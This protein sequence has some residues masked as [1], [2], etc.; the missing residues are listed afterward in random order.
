MNT[1]VLYALVFLREMFLTMFHKNF[2]IH[3]VI[4]FTVLIFSSERLIAQINYQDFAS[5]LGLTSDTGTTI[6]GGSGVSF[7]DYNNDGFD[8]ITLT[9]GENTPVRFYTNLNGSFFI[10]ED[11][12]PVPVSGN[13]NY[14]TRCSNWI[15]YDNDGDK[16]LFLTSDTDGNRLFQNQNGSLVDVTIS[17]GFPTDNLV[18][19]G[20]SWGDINNDGCLDV[21]ISNRVGGTSIT[22]YF[23]VNNCDGTFTDATVS[24]GLSN[25]SELTFCSA[26]FD[27][28]NDGY[29]DLYVANDKIMPNYLYKNNGDGTFTDVSQSSGTNLVIDAMSVTIGDYNSDGFFDIFM[30]NT[31]ENIST[32]YAEGTVL[33]KNNGDETFTDVTSTAQTSLD[34]FSWGSNFIDSENDGDLDIYVNTQYTNSDGQPTFGFFENNNDGTFSMPVLPGFTT[35]DY[36]S[37]SS[38]IGDYN[39]DGK[40]DILSHNDDNEN[41][42]LWVNTSDTSA[43][44]YI[45][46]HLE[47]IISNKDGIGS[48]IEIST[49]GKKQFGYVL[50]GEGYMSQNSFTQHFG[51]GNS[52]VIDYIK[53]TWLSGTVDQFVDVPANQTYNIVEGTGTAL[54]VNNNEINDIK[55]YP[56]PVK[57]RLMI[58]AKDL[59]KLVHL[60]NPLGQE[61]MRLEPNSLDADIDT[62]TLSTGTYLVRINTVDK[63][64]TVR[65][66]KK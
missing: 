8:D 50:G 53:V 59:I 60:C 45:K 38:A 21:Y 47:G 11:L 19:Y 55:V 20:A 41:A 17:A 34:S 26:F 9:T 66:I 58:K 5:S 6:F 29:Q 13:Y 51:I 24:A 33:L 35:N 16:D 1:K 28:N 54:S 63:S 22:N 12:L 49:N 18:T 46:V 52:L 25:N 23:F 10:L 31:P 14:K 15:D 43:N 61:V 57:N 56:I 42:S 39:N 36:R 64:E 4:G 37:Y 3:F 7:V 44:N 2:F 65:I 32:E 27:F 40:L 30:T 62:S 48:T